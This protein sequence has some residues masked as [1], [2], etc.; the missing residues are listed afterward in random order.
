[1]EFATLETLNDMTSSKDI[2]RINK[3]KCVSARE[4]WEL[5]WIKFVIIPAYGMWCVILKPPHPEEVQSPW[6]II[7]HPS[8]SIDDIN[9]KD[10]N[11]AGIPIRVR[12]VVVA[13][14]HHDITM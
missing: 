3:A 7:E 12:F 9:M 5:K 4:G 1:M 6:Q 14:Q 11:N 10:A 2:L 8:P 13:C